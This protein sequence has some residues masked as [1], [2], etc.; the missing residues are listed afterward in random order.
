MV[1]GTVL[2]QFFIVNKFWV[3]RFIMIHIGELDLFVSLGPFF[4]IGILMI[5]FLPEK[6]WPKLLLLLFISGIAAGIEMI[7]IKFGFLAYHLNNWNILY[8]LI[9]YF[10]ALMSA[11]GFHYIYNWKKMIV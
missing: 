8:S 4:G 3:Q 6:N 5:R 11:L 7:S 10:L 9:A 2:E 1:V